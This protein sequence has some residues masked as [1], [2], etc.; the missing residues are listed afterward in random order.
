MRSVESRLR[1]L[2]NV[3]SREFSDVLS[4]IREGRYYD[5]LDDRQKDRYFQYHGQDRCSVEKVRA[6]ICGYYNEDPLHFKLEYKKRPPT[7]AEFEERV[8]E[9]Q[10][11]FLEV[12]EKYNSPYE[13]G[14][15]DK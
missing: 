6:Q 9:V 15:E 4:L 12:E 5:E 14:K 13:R 10:A 11:Y 1:K 3:K 7:R 2:E 8:R